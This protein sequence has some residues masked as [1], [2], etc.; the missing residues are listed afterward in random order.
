MVQK[1]LY[2]RW[3]RCLP[4][5]LLSPWAHRSPTIYWGDMKHPYLLNKVE[6]TLRSV[7]VC[8]RLVPGWNVI[9]QAT[10]WFSF[11]SSWALTQSV[12]CDVHLSDVPIT[13]SADRYCIV[14]HYGWECTACN[15]DYVSVWRLWP[16]IL[17]AAAHPAFCAVLPRSVF[18]CP[19]QLFFASGTWLW[20]ASLLYLD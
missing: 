18:L 17:G 16:S 19:W 20:E 5:S 15:P 6:V 12:T 11:R 13:F 2:Q 7:S 10:I 14:S 1:V 4:A 8:S 9:S 3:I